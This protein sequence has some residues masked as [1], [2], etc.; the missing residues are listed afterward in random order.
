MERK[1]IT[2]VASQF[3]SHYQV[4]VHF[5]SPMLCVCVFVENFTHAEKLNFP[6]AEALAGTRCILFVYV[7][8]GEHLFIVCSVHTLFHNLCV[9]VVCVFSSIHP[10]IHPSNQP[11][12]HPWPPIAYQPSLIYTLLIDCLLFRPIAYT[13][14]MRHPHVPLLMQ[15]DKT[16]RTAKKPQPGQPPP[17]YIRRKVGHVY[18]TLIWNK[19]AVQSR[20]ACSVI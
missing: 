7:D 4:G 12:N 17:L 20:N 19:V 16:P 2:D 6:Q 18:K 11:T 5:I 13:V 9:F 1:N 10:S 14:H 15:S 3:D 8:V